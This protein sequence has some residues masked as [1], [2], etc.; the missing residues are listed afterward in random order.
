MVTAPARSAAK[1]ALSGCL[2]L[3][4]AMGVGRFAFTPMLPLMIAAHDVTLDAG[5]ALASANYLGYLVGALV[6]GRL[7]QAPG[8]LARG[9]L[10]AVAVVTIGM[11]LSDTV[12]TWMVLRFLAG[13]ASA[14]ALVHVSALCLARLRSLARPEL[15]GWVFGGVGA[16]IS[17]VGL[18]CLVLARADIAP[19]MDWM[20]IGALA[21]TLAVL[22]WPVLG[23]HAAARHGSSAIQP[24]SSGQA[25]L[26]LCY[27]AYGFGYIV[28]ATFL[29]AM[30]R[31]AVADP[32]IFGWTWPVFGFAAFLCTVAAGTL[33]Q[34][35]GDRRLW[36]V[37]HVVMAAGVAAPLLV[38]GMAGLLLAAL[39]VGAMFMVT[40][41]VALREAA[42]VAGP[43][44]ARLIA[45]MTAA[46]AVGQIAGPLVVSTV[47]ATQGF[48]LASW[49][50]V[51]LLLVSAA[52]LWLPSSP[53][54]QEVR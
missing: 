49:I 24:G 53:S 38:T 14:L 16:G 21:T 6:A 3:A 44:A 41:L 28:P 10:A 32:A 39:A 52:G 33:G 46:F 11:G 37:S 51:V 40:S 29:P 4:V 20:L 15:S 13:V 22:A 31:E 5:G 30:A 43:D 54:P 25:R 35:M 50:A 12:F 17:L 2:A 7:P 9:S 26:I 34:R 19:S 27:G 47:G 1:V 23:D 18:L 42:R 36:A 45:S 48:A 8:T